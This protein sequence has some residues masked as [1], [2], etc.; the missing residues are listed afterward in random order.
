MGTICI[1]YVFR[2]IIFT[3]KYY[4]Y[5][6]SLLDIYITSFI[7]VKRKQHY[8]EIIVYTNKNK[9]AQIHMAEN[10]RKH[11]DNSNISNI[12]RRHDCFHC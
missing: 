1:R 9:T 2:T 7:G 12:G 6:V 5:M 8:W 4:L 10:E 11:V 3:E